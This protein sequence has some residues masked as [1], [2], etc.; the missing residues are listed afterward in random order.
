MLSHT[1]FLDLITFL[2]FL[3]CKIQCLFSNKWVIGAGITTENLITNFHC[4]QCPFFKSLIIC[5]TRVIRQM[6]MGFSFAFVL[7]SC[8]GFIITQTEIVVSRY[9]RL[10][11]FADK[12]ERK[13]LVTLKTAFLIWEIHT[14]FAGTHFCEI[15]KL[16]MWVLTFGNNFSLNCAIIIPIVSSKSN[17][18][19]RMVFQLIEKWVLDRPHNLHHR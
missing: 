13:Q 18:N 6:C 10:F 16:F 9:R 12:K 7:F 11:N 4:N 2:L 14:F 8:C 3:F 17:K 1:F 5:E 19:L 15:L